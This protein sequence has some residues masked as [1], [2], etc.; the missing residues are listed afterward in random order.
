MGP[1]IDDNFPTVA[2]VHFLLHILL[3]RNLCYQINFD[4]LC[5]RSGCY[6]SFDSERGSRIDLHC[7]LPSLRGTIDPCPCMERKLFFDERLLLL[8]E[9]I[10]TEFTFV[11][12]FCMQL[13]RMLVVTARTSCSRVHVSSWD[14]D[15]GFFLGNKWNWRGIRAISIK[16][17]RWA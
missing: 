11:T 10:F 4:S 7:S 9:A 17:W 16:A 3:L 6:T 8:F 1:H 13:A 5:E 14:I 15:W 12:D 2:L